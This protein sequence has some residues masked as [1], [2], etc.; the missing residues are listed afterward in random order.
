MTAR[1]HRSGAVRVFRGIS[2]ELAL[3]LRVAKLDF[4]QAF[5]WPSGVRFAWFR[6]QQRGRFA[7]TIFVSKGAFDP[8]G[9]GPSHTP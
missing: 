7:G 1:E 4:C 2:E 8:I 9:Y 5:L 3:N 6:R